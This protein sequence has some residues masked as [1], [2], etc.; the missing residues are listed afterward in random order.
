MSAFNEVKV[1]MS[2]AM[3]MVLVVHHVLCVLLNVRLV[4]NVYSSPTKRTGLPQF[5]N[6]GGIICTMSIEVSAELDLLG[7]TAIE[8]KLQDGVPHALKQLL[9]AGIKVWVLTGDNV[10]TAINIG[11]SCNLL[12]VIHHITSYHW[13]VIDVSSINNDQSCG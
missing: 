5:C 11:I 1:Q 7:A 6:N 13:H 4:C 12:E 9:D 2:A 10:A 8:D 3:L